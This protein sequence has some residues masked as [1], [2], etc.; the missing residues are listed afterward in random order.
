MTSTD[1]RPSDA[2]ATYRRMHRT[3]VVTTMVS[4]IPMGV[5]LIVVQSRS[6][7]EAAIVGVGL[8]AA[9]AVLTQWGRS[10]YPKF[11]TAALITCAAVWVVGAL[12]FEDSTAFFPL[13]VAGSM[14]VPRLLRH[15]AAA[16]AGF[17]L[18]VAGVG[19][20]AVWR[21]PELS[22]LEFAAIPGGV[23][24]FAAALM[25][26]SDRYWVLFQ[27]L[28]RAREAEAELGIMRERVRF[29]SELHDIQGHTLHVVKLKVALAE[30]LVEQD[31]A[32]SSQELREVHELVGDTITETKDLVYAQRRLNLSSELENAKNLFEAAGIRVKLL[33]RQGED[34]Q[35]ENRQEEDPHVELL[36]Q[37]LRETTTNILRHAQASRVEI[38][39][40]PNSLIVTNDGAQGD[41]QPALR[42]L[43]TLGRRV[44]DRGGRLRVHRQEGRFTTAADFSEEGR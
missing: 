33:R 29:A 44:A 41:G 6:W 1:A 8:V 23:A 14:T 25:L 2:E 32:R 11:G 42:G 37:V 4:I 31:P 5:I 35:E 38:T 26:Y 30:K 21:N 12:F 40:T 16:I 28:E 19:V 20:A 3:T 10:G 34:E 17:G 15:R 27:E 24:A 36:G 13:A 43:E 18:L 39:L 7:W 9:V 22:L